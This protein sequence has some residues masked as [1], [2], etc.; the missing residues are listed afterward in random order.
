M[1]PQGAVTG[2]A[3]IGRIESVVL[4]THVVAGFAALFGGLGALLTEKAGRRHRLCGRSYVV[5]M[6]GVSGTALALYVID[7]TF[8]RQFLALVA[9]FSF[10]F[11]FSGYRVL[12]RK[13][14]A[15]G[16]GI[17]DWVA[18]GLFGLASVGILG[19]GV[20]LVLAGTG[21]APVMLV[22]GG[23]GVVFAGI[24][25]RGYR[26]ESDPGAWVGEH[27]TRMGAGYIATVSAFSSVN[28]LVLPGLLRWLWPTL[29]G[30][31]ALVYVRRRFDERFVRETA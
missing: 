9:V 13:R 26:R 11:A 21:F 7:P 2:V 16:P 4:W 28:L 12:S 22:F 10:Y 20:R 1:T 17:V 5:S 3:L 19:M 24:D 15:A 18:V 31:P 30:V 14:P 27:V 23:I 25:V 29:V 6:A 8:F